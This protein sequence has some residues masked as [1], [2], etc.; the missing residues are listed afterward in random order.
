MSSSRKNGF[1][2]VAFTAVS[3]VLYFLFAYF[4]KRESTLILFSAF[5]VLSGAY[6]FTINRAELLSENYN[7]FVI[8]AF[9]LRLLFLFS[10]PALSDDFYRFIWDGRLIE[11]GISPYS[12]LPNKI[13]KDQLIGGPSNIELFQKMNSPNYFSVYPPVL[14]LLFFISVKLSFGYDALAV[15]NL[16]LFILLAEF[17]TFIYLKKILDFLKINKTKIFLYFLNPLII[18]ELTGNLHFEAVM[19]FFLIASLY[20]LMLNRYSFSAGFIALAISTKMIPLLFLPLILKKI[21]WK[22]GMVYSAFSAGIIILLF[23]PFIE[24][25]LISNVGNSVSLYF[26]KFEFNASFYYLLREIGFEMVGYNTISIIGKVLPII[27][28]CLILFVSFI[29]TKV[30]WQD[31]FRRALTILFIYYLLS[32]VVH[33]WYV[34]LLVLL[35][36]FI[37]NK[38]AIIWSILIFGS[39][40][41][42]NSTPF[43]ECFWVNVVEYSVVILFF[44]FGSKKL[45]AINVFN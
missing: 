15:I 18:I 36:I 21:G 5:A 41:A 24:K 27:S 8:V 42:Y 38:F 1:Y 11:E 23:L 43:K 28:T 13:I 17:G 34:S 30:T 33:P 22:N 31:F 32:L 2:F 19:I 6:F 44:L 25:E 12:Y 26:Q 16:R 35:S 4:L 9:S 20:Y 45:K 39:Y 37:E 7:H 40:F 29:G 3:C 10:I 14:Q